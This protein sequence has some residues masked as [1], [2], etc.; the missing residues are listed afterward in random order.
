MRALSAGGLKSAQEETLAKEV[1]K[2]ERS[3][4]A[5]KTARLRALR[6]AKEATDKEEADRLAAEKP[7]A[8][9]SARRKRVPASAAK[10]AKLV[11]M[12]Y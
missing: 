8:V 4:T 1:R 12:T 10:P 6:L 2:K 3:A 11:R 9:A 7:D 5:A